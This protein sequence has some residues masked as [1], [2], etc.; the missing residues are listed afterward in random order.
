MCAWSCSGA[1]LTSTSTGLG[2]STWWTTENFRNGRNVNVNSHK[3][4]LIRGVENETADDT[5]VAK[6]KDSTAV[7]SSTTAPNKSSTRRPLPPLPQ[8]EGRHKHHNHPQHKAIANVKNHDANKKG[9]DSRNSPM[10]SIDAR[11]LK[12]NSKNSTITS[13]DFAAATANRSLAEL[14]LY[15]DGLAAPTPTPTADE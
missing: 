8:S 7:E 14:E 13:L 6:L 3:L 10:T 15:L 12:L 1:A 2:A 9:V 5:N 4:H 11:A